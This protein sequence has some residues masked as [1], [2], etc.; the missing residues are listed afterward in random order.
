MRHIKGFTLI[1]ILITIAI[2]GILLTV[3]YPSYL[4]Y[5]TKTHRT[6]GQVALMD[7]ASR[8]ERYYIDNNHTYVGA[9]FA[10]L[11]ISSTSS[12][13][14]YTLTISQLSDTTYLLTATPTGSQLTNDKLCGSLTIDQSGQ[15]GQT[16]TGT[17]KDCW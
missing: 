11:K 10:T 14:F 12:R 7:L 15:K 5:I 4:R 2:I 17:Q 13:G 6:D 8:M 16:G 9:S 3:A 1:E